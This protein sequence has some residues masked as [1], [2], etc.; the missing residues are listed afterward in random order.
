MKTRFEFNKIR[1][2]TDFLN[3]LEK[4]DQLVRIKKSVNPKFELA[5]IVSKLDK[6]K[7]MLFESVNKQDKGSRKCFGNKIQ[8]LHYQ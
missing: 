6:G 5:G 4:T 8:G 2:F 1:R 7:A 3:E